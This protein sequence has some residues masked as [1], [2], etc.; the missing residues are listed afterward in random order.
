M[1][2]ATI[3]R[4]YAKALL[5]LAEEAKQTP[6]V[7]KA[8]AAFAETWASSDTLRDLFENPSVSAESRQKVLDQVA[9]RLAAPPLL[10]N[11]LKLLADR[12]RMALLPELAAAFN[13]LAQTATCFMALICAL[14]PTRDTEIPTLMAGRTPELKRSD[15]RKIWPSVMEMTFVG[16]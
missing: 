3:S 12:G 10:K 5:E 1:S 6:T 9:T 8:L 7:H 14:P 4:R 13:G 16:M 11:T 2:N 15:S